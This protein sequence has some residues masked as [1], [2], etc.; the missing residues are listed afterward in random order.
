M[1]PPT[2]PQK[3][4]TGCAGMLNWLGL[5]FTLVFIA[6]VT[7]IRLGAL[8]S[9]QSTS[10][11][12]FTSSGAIS[13]LIQILLIGAPLVL[14]GRFLPD[15]RFR[16][17]S[18]AWAWAAIAW[19]LVTLP[20]QWW[21]ISGAQGRYLLQI[22]GVGGLIWLLARRLRAA[23]PTAS[24]GLTPA[25]EAGDASLPPANAAQ[26]LFDMASRHGRLLSSTLPPKQSAPLLMMLTALVVGCAAII[27]FISRGALGSPLDTLLAVG[28][29]F[30]LGLSAAL[31]LEYHLF[32]PLR[33]LAA[34]RREAYFLSLLG[35]AGLLIL[36]ASA[37]AFPFGGLQLLLFIIL[38]AL[39]LL[40]AGLN[41]LF[42]GP[43]SY[44]NLR[45]AAPRL[46]VWAALLS[47]AA[48][49]PLTWID[50]DELNINLADS[51]SEIWAM[52]L[53][54][55]FY[56]A[57]VAIVAGLFSGGLLI[58]AARR[59]HLLGARRA[60]LGC[61]SILLIALALAVVCNQTPLLSTRQ[62]TWNGER[63]FVILKD[64]AD[65][66]AAAE[67]TNPT[68]R[69]A[70]VYRT[71]SDHAQTTQAPL[72][73]QLNQLGIAYTSYYLVNAVEIQADPPLRAWLALQPQVDR[74]LDSPRLRPLPPTTSN[75]SRFTP[76]AA[77]PREPTWNIRAIRA[78]AVWEDFDVRGQGILIG[79]SDSGVEVSHPALRA[80]YRGAVEPQSPNW[81]DAWYGKAQPYDLGGHGTHT[82]GTILGDQVGVAPQAQFI[83]CSNLAR[84]LANPALYLDCWQFMLAPYPQ[85]GDALT[86][87]LPEQGAQVLN[88][89]WGCPPLEGCD[90]DVFLSAAR[91]LKA[92][93]IFVVVSG[94]N[95]GP[96]CGSLTTP[97]AIYDEV[98]SVGAIDQSGEL[99]SFS[100]IGPTPDGRVK[101]DIL[102][103]G[104]YILSTIPGGSYARF[105]G[106]SMGGP[107]VVGV[108]ALMW[109]ANPN[110]VGQ[111]DATAAILRRTARPYTG[112]LPGCLQA[113]SYPSTAA[114]YGV[115]DAYAAVQAA[116]A[117]P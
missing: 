107:H 27:P 79:Q 83:A 7:F 35:A 41:A 44:P 18:R 57:G 100:S 103:P 23:A 102:A 20:A 42:P 111:V 49:G 13:Q 28:L 9:D 89:S 29:A 5:L 63:L 94:G 90:N 106:T 66:S 113:E 99:A 88:N 64:Q 58:W 98:F 19:P 91:A 2:P 36:M 105:S 8:Q 4:S 3:E 10:L 32:T 87:G 65:L 54:M 14:A 38:P 33:S 78:E 43:E 11:K 76:P 30:A 56:S 6:I 115:V 74:V 50:P 97:P 117:Y 84:N 80:K 40:L 39:A 112:A 82:T 108:V 95:D 72:L 1:T 114:G 69:R 110:L 101:P 96:A 67:F 12:W 68:E 15:A 70:W 86:Q 93:G 52:A 55:S 73:A 21:W 77:A 37:L 75:A 51:L 62:S 46:W 22:V 17:I 45:H 71:L 16:T 47:L 104:V 34:N 81:L 116:L 92:A 25:V 59:P 26:A 53:G 85:G 60:Q 48:L 109:S 31:L 24:V 61:I